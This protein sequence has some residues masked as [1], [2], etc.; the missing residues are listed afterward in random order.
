MNE[1]VEMNVRYVTFE[2]S[3]VLKAFQSSYI[4]ASPHSD[5]YEREPVVSIDRQVNLIQQLDVDIL[6][7]GDHLSRWNTVFSRKNY[8]RYHPLDWQCHSQS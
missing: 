4:L 1:A 2:I 8:N 6:L 7:Q 5:I 3:D